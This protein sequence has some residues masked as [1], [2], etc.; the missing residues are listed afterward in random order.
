MR[1]PII[2]QR[3][4]RY[5]PK[6]VAEEENALKEILQE[7]ALYALATTDFF[8]HALFQGG[9]ALRILYQ[10]PRFSEDLYFILKKPNEKFHW[11]PYI[12]QMT[13]A[14]KLLDIEPDLEDKTKD[15][16]V[17]TMWLKDN[18]IGKML[19]LQFKHHAHQKLKIKFEI[20]TNPP[21][22]SHIEVKFLD[23]PMDCAISAQD[24][25]SNFA[26]RCHALLCRDHIK[27]RDWFDLAW[28]VARRIPVNLIFLEAAINQLGTWKDQNIKVTHDW[29]LHQLE[30]KVLT[31]DWE[32]I[33]KD[34]A[35]FLVDVLQKESL[36]LWGEA[37]FTEKVKEMYR[38]NLFFFMISIK[39]SITHEQDNF[40]KNWMKMYLADA[41]QKFQ[42]DRLD[43]CNG[44]LENAS[45]PSDEVS[46][47]PKYLHWVS[48]AEKI[49]EKVLEEQL[50]ELQKQGGYQFYA[51]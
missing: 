48:S 1:H 10:L 40:M 26:G 12:E 23:F 31:L 30:E 43:L 8:S 20:D 5:Q 32:S 51:L 49:N 3:L 37:F 25:P 29:L 44:A 27:G 33:K 16:P 4:E 39:D 14:F 35:P 19:H 2:E 11:Q 13:K 6:T 7:I 42:A 18:S 24:L 41:I 22:G 50:K 28:Y 45:L 34:V 36:N 15:K 47:D 17:K 9:T 38:T 46:R 21:A